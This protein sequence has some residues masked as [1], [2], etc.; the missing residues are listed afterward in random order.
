M[1]CVAGAARTGNTGV[2]MATKHGGRF[3]V[4]TRPDCLFAL[5]LARTPQ[6]FN[7]SLLGAPSTWCPYQWHHK[8]IPH[9]V[10]RLRQVIYYLPRHLPL[11]AL[12]EE[13][14]VG[15]GYCRINLHNI[16]MYYIPGIGP[17]SQR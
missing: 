12:R 17:D 6:R 1:H 13:Q 16:D 15:E 3:G 4:Q 10:G 9:P 14:P 7:P 8:L 5:H 2:L 11:Q